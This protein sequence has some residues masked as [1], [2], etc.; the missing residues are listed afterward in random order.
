MGSL[1]RFT[2]AQDV[3]ADRPRID[4]NGGIA[5]DVR[6]T[7]VVQ[8]VHRTVRPSLEKTAI[9]HPPPPRHMIDIRAYR[10]Q[11]LDQ[12]LVDLPLGVGPPPSQASG[13]DG[14]HGVKS[15]WMPRKPPQ[16]AGMEEAA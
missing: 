15:L 6:H 8:E 1:A 3:V 5:K 13:G 7:T 2:V 16:A 12:F 10:S 9:H 14:E 11:P 4:F